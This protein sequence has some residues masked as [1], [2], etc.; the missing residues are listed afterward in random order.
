MRASIKINTKHTHGTG[1]TMSSVL[2]TSLAQLL[3][4]KEAFEKAHDYV[5]RA[6][7]SAPCLGHGNGPINHCHSINLD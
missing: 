1:C 5:Q 3:E 4:I 6:I 7:K 2:A